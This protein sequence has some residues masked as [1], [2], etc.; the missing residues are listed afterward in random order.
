MWDIS[1][2]VNGRGKD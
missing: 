2:K 1:E